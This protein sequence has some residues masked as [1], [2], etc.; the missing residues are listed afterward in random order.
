MCLVFKMLDSMKRLLLIVFFS[1]MAVFANAQMYNAVCTGAGESVLMKLNDIPIV[2][3]KSLTQQLQGWPK[4]FSKDEYYMNVRGLCLA[5]LDGNGTD[6]IIFGAD[7]A[8]YAYKGDGTCLWRVDLQGIAYYPPS[9]ADIDNDGN[10]E[11]LMYTR[12]PAGTSTS[13]FYIFDKDGNIRDGFPKSYASTQII[14]G[15]PVI[16]DFDGDRQMEIIVAKFGSSQSKLYVYEPDGSIRSGFPKS[17]T[18][19]F[20]VTPSVGYDSRSGRMID[21]FIVLNTTEAIYAFDLNGNLLDG[22]P[23]QDDNVKFSYQSPLICHTAEKTVFVGASH[24]DAPIFYS[25]ETNGQFSEGWPVPTASNAWTYTAP[26]VAGL[27]DSFDFYMFT[28]RESDAAIHAMR[29]DGSNINGFPFARTIM[30]EGGSEGVTTYMY[31]NDLEKIYIFGTSI[32]G[33]ANGEGYVHI[34]EAN[35]D[36]SD[37]HETDESPLR[38]QGLSFLSAVNLGDVNGNGKLDLVVQSYDQ[39]GEGAD[40]IHVSVFETAYDYNPDYMYGTYKGR[41]DRCGFVTPFGLDLSVDDVFSDEIS[42][43]PNPARDMISVETN[44]ASDLQI[45][46]LSGETMFSY[47]GCSEKCDIDVSGLKPGVYFCRIKNND[48]VQTVK[49]VKL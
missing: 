18:G 36:L 37:F 34:F 13:Y 24:G 4:T 16:A 45:V 29:P 17:V 20:A 15:S 38:I 27:G 30:D 21:S 48:K 41:N 12:A 6:E 47:I 22:F 44:V 7:T 31:S 9:C 5:D 32:S 43:F 10:L 42:I 39:M 28:Q 33:D 49:F 35:P 25:L 3:E 11:I 40:S 19:R 26:T 8:I 46:D 1:V 14:I 2:A 23:V